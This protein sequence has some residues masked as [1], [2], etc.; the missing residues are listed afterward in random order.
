M[1]TAGRHIKFS[2]QLPHSRCCV[3]N[4]RRS[5]IKR[6]ETKI[7]TPEHHCLLSNI[8]IKSISPDQWFE[9][10]QAGLCQWGFVDDPAAVC[11]TPLP[12]PPQTPGESLA[13]TP[14]RMSTPYQLKL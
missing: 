9:I 4:T 7:K 10:C 11:L 1:S 5:M 14:E 8:P 3:T 13:E 6:L 2:A 12:S